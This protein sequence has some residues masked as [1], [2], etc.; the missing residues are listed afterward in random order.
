[1]KKYFLICLLSLNIAGAGVSAQNLNEW[2]QL[3]QCKATVR[4]TQH[5]F[6]FYSIPV[7]RQIFQI[8]ETT[9]LQKLNTGSGQWQMTCKT[10]VPENRSDALDVEFHFTLAKGV[11]P[12]TSVSIDFTFSNWSKSNYVLM[13]GAAYNG[14]RFESR[15]IRY[16]PKLLDSRDIGPDKPI[17][18]F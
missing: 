3:Q 8:D 17:D 4:F 15:R 18:Y 11:A 6:N 5:D 1:M 12:Q 9:E 7:S 16:S 10:T 14:N 13:P 2:L